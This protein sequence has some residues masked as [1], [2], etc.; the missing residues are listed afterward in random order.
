V[1]TFALI[2]ALVIT[3]I[4]AL[5]GL[6]ANYETNLLTTQI[7]VLMPQAAIITSPGRNISI[8]AR[9]AAFGAMFP[10]RA[11][12]DSDN[13]EI[14]GFTG[15]LSVVNSLAC[16]I[17]GDYEDLREKIALVQRGGC[18]FYDKVL[19]LQEWGAVAVIVGDNLYHRGLVTMYTKDEFDLARVPAAFVSRD[20]YDILSEIDIITITRLPD[21]V[22]MMNT[23]V[24]L[25]VSPLCSLSLI[26]GLLLFHR[27]Y[28]LMK[29]RAPKSFVESLPTRIW[30][31][32]NVQDASMVG[33]RPE[34]VWVSSGEC[35]ICLD[36]YVSG[37][38][39]VMRLP[40]GHEFHADCISKWLIFRKKTCPICK[41]DVTEASERT[42]LIDREESPIIDGLDS[43][44]ISV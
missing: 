29:E 15:S 31:S 23:V 44:D 38:S 30:Q 43:S 28:R 20:S 10:T 27:R 3:L 13:G 16:N 4:V 14:G 1:L 22:P 32:P 40:C 11:T 41:K 39:S 26:Y 9:P 7:P 35:I 2:I 6:A 37:V 12:E 5:S 36:D 33:V 18:G 19:N 42:P 24:F 8:A 34:K 21:Q 17:K 25:M